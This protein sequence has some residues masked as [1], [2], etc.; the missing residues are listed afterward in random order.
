MQRGAPAA[1]LGEVEASTASHNASRR[2]S[3]TWLTSVTAMA[4]GDVHRQRVMVTRVPFAGRGLDV[5]VVREPARAAQT[6]PQPSARRVAVL[7]RQ[8]DV[9][10]AG[11]V[12]VEGQT[13]AAAPEVPRPLDGDRAAAAVLDGVARQLARRRDDLGLIDQVE[14]ELDGALPDGLADRHHVLGGLD[15]SLIAKQDRHPRAVP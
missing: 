10:D 1:L 14:A 5:E 4:A 2:P 9:R 3:A 15:R 12:V 7:H 8:L 13:E 6:E 11:A